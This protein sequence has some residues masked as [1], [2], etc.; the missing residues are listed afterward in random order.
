MYQTNRNIQ[1]FY[2]KDLYTGRIIVFKDYDE[3]L[4]E[5][6]SVFDSQ[7]QTHPWKPQPPKT[8]DLNVTG[9]DTY[10]L[11][12]TDED[13]GSPFL[14]RY[15]Y[16][17]DQNRHLDLRDYRYE[18]LK[19]YAGNGKKEVSKPKRKYIGR[20]E[21]KG[22][23]PSLRRYVGKK[24]FRS[25]SRGAKRTLKL[26]ADPEY[27]VY[28]RKKSIPKD[29]DDIRYRRSHESWKKQKKRKQWM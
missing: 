9:K 7:E 20:G 5:V 16:F 10:D 19:K 27:N 24:G 18:A 14:R 13:S 17:D 8:Y 28:I 12:I 23:I 2:R 25:L 26:A 15:V 6:F 1:K 22:P 11:Y 21:R 4:F 29:M 3:F